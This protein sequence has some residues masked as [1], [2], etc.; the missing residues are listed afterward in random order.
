MRWMEMIRLRTPQGKEEGPARM[1]FDSVRQIGGE[2]GLIDARV[3]INVV[4]PSDLALH[5]IW[6][7]ESPE[8]QGSRAALGITQTLKTFGLVDHSVWTDHISGG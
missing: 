4:F 1:L 7:T 6:D 8:T 5:L 3:L 2:Q